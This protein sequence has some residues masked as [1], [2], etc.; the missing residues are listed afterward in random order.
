MEFIEDPAER[1]TAVTDVILA[2][3]ALGGIWFLGWNAADSSEILK[4]LIWSAAIGLIGLASAL[5]AAT[6]GLVMSPGLH[7]R[8]WQVLNACLALAVSLF[9][10]GVVYDVWGSVA[11]QSV[12]P[13]LIV[14]GL[15]FYA[16]TLVFPG[17]FF[18]FIVYEGLTLIFALMAYIYMTFGRELSGAPLI[19][20]G[21]L[22]SILAA[23]LQACKSITVTVIWEFDHNGIFHIVQIIGIILLLIGLR[24]SLLGP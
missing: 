16:A 9:A 13:F 3:V 7:N 24:Q 21:I 23:A 8:L 19:S 14:A 18:I 1:T 4:I 5:G 17:Y 11:C 10:A 12:L 2:M 22:V 6:H 15:F 20:A